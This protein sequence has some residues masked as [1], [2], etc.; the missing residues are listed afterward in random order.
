MYKSEGKTESSKVRFDGKVKCA[1]ALGIIELPLGEELIEI[2]E[3]RNA[4]HIDAEIRK[5]FQYELKLST[6]AYRRLQPFK[7][8]IVAW[9]KKSEAAL[10]SE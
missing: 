9:L 6:M 10:K 1:V 7:D 4:I 8:Q 5:N 2:Y 3:A